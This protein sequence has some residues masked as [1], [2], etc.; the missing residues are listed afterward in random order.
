MVPRL[1]FTQSVI[2]KL[3]LHDPKVYSLHYSSEKFS[4]FA[5]GR[6]KEIMAYMEKGVNMANIVK[7]FDVTWPTIHNF[8]KTRKL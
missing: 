6:E 8:I 2:R 7:I 5:T 1:I 4:R 3:S